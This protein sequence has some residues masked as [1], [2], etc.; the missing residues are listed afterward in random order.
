VLLEK[1]V[2]DPAPYVVELDQHPL[3]LQ[4]QARLADM[5]GRKTVPNIMVNGKSI[6]G[7]DEIAEYD[8]EKILVEKIKAVGGN[9]VEVTERFV[10][11]V[12]RPAKHA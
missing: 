7:S 2:I 5:T 4:I 8:K 11:D 6:G 1:Y 3:G 10:E 12:Q 9:P